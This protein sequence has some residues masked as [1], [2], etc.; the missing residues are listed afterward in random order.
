MR[1]QGVINGTSY[2]GIRM[3]YFGAVNGNCLA[4]NYPTPSSSYYNDKY[5]EWMSVP[6]SNSKAGY[7][8]KGL[9]IWCKGALGAK[10]V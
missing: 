1:C 3:P 2:I 5:V 7:R 9:A 4:Y 6:L 8:E 10:R